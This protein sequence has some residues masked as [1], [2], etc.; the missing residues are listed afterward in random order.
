MGLRL[1]LTQ[2]WLVL[3]AP[4]VAGVSIAPAP[5]LAAALSSSCPGLSAPALLS[6]FASSCAKVNLSNFSVAPD[7]T[8]TLTDTDTET[9]SEGGFGLAK[10]DATASFNAQKKKAENQSYAWA[11]GIGSRYEAL[12]DSTAAIFG[13]NFVVNKKAKDKSDDFFSFDFSALL[14]LV[15]KVTN[16]ASEVAEASGDV[17]FLL[18]ASDK[19]L[20]NRN[21]DEL[22]ENATLID[23]FAINGKL[24]TI[25]SPDF[26][27]SSFDST[28]FNPIF[29]E[30]TEAIAP[31]GQAMGITAKGKYSREFDKLTYLTLVEVKQNRAF[32]RAPEPMTAVALFCV[33]AALGAGR[34]K[35]GMRDEG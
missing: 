3:V 19:K 30:T 14:E 6:T 27:L 7:Q 32:V 25:A 2:R 17:S 13:Y 23:A 5:T 16:P 20:K 1:Q 34:V 15:T 21:L 35:R 11:G 29:D 10:A 9:T 18:Y 12:A 31:F 28:G 22:E 4:L 26:A 24:S 8:G 33:A